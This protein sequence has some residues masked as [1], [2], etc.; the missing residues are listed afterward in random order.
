MSEDCFWLAKLTVPQ[1]WFE[2]HSDFEIITNYFIQQIHLL[3][4]YEEAAAQG[5]IAGANASARVKHYLGHS[6]HYQPLILDRTKAY[7]GVMIDDLV[8]FFKKIIK[9]R[10]LLDFAWRD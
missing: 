2:Q 10:N 4:G 6:E 8:K 1:V 5:L 7:I 9:I 3:S